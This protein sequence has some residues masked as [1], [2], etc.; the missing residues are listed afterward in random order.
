MRKVKK[1]PILSAPK[2]AIIAENRKL[3]KKSSASTTRNVPHEVNLNGG[4]ARPK[5]LDNKRNQ[6]IR[7]TFAKELESKDF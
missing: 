4:K 1:N 2:L 6:S 3:G 7:L 5:P